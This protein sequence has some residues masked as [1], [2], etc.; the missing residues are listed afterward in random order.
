MEIQEIILTIVS[1]VIPAIISYFVARHQGKM[2]IKKASEANKAEIERLMKQH[3]INLEAIK[4]QHRLEMETKEK[5]QEYKLQIMQKEYDL[6]IQ[7]QQQ[8]KAN[9]M[10]ASMFGGVI[11]DFI[12]DPTKTAQKLQELQ[13]AAE[14]FKN[15]KNDGK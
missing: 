15:Q 3:E 1:A 9:D 6:K 12:K 14:L 2:D 10:M 8:S 11:G 4:E 7:E 13:N 5:E